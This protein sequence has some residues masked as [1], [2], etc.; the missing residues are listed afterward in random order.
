MSPGGAGPGAREAAALLL[1]PLAGE[2]FR[3][4]GEMRDEEA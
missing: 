4:I 2:V 1:I 3:Q